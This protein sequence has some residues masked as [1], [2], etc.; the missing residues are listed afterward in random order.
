MP[1]DIIP[2]AEKFIKVGVYFIFYGCIGSTP[3]IWGDG[4]Q[5]I[6]RLFWSD[7]IC[8]WG[9][10]IGTKECCLNLFGHQTPKAKV[11]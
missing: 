8:L 10:E 1:I 3:E 2:W 6:P 5:T 7:N 11:V 9:R 4:Q